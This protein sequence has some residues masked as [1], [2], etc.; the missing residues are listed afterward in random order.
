MKYIITYEENEY[1]ERRYAYSST[2]ELEKDKELLKQL[3][4]TVIFVEPFA[5]ATANI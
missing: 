1:G 5:D 4:N 2:L 3:G